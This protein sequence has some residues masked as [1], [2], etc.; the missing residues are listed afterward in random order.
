MVSPSG[1]AVLEGCLD[2]PGSI[3]S[4]ANGSGCSAFLSH[5]FSTTSYG[6]F[7]KLLFCL[8]QLVSFNSLQVRI[9]INTFV[10]LPF[11]VW[12]AGTVT[13][14]RGFLQLHE[15][16]DHICLVHL[17]RCLLRINVLGS[18]DVASL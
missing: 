13:F 12:C 9:F 17:E 3:A 18:S 4:F 10:Y 16:Q 14:V 2:Y 15:A 11:L 7:N 1:D 6:L 8:N 5:L